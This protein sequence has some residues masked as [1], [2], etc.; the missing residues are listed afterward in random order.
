[1][2]LDDEAKKLGQQGEQKGEP[3]LKSQVDQKMSSD[4][5]SNHQIK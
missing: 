1:M 5:Q 4:N 3:E 2:D